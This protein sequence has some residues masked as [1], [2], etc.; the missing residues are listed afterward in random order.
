MTQR[1]TPR[2]QAIE[3]IAAYDTAE[4]GEYEQHIVRIARTWLSIMKA[5]HS[6]QGIVNRIM[7]EF[8]QPVPD[9]YGGGWQ[10]LK[11]RFTEWAIAE[12]WY[13]PN[14]PRDAREKKRQRSSR[15]GRNARA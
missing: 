8:D 12:E 6:V 9:G 1:K 10:D 2:Q 11:A 7:D 14:E 4:A 15:R 3:F 5:K 13:D